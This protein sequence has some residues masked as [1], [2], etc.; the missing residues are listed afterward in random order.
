MLLVDELVGIS[1]MK[2]HPL[3]LSTY[4]AEK[5]GTRDQHAFRDNLSPLQYDKFM[6]LH[7]PGTNMIQEF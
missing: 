7:S 5:L 1:M 2:L 6:I 4:T 3:S